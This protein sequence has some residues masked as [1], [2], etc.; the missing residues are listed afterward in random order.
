MGERRNA[1]RVLVG[2]PEGR[3]HFEGPGVDWRII[4]KW[5]SEM[6]DGSINWIWLTIGTD[7]VLLCMR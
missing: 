1:Y 2:I 4:L 7:G 3:K 5:I 6:W